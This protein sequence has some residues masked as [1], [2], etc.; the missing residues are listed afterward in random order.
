MN[1]LLVFIGGGLGSLI[2]YGIS[3]ATISHNKSLFPYAT[4]ITNILS[5]ICIGLLISYLP[6][7]N[8]SE[9]GKLL[10]ITGFCGGF[11][12]FSTLSLEV[13]NLIEKNEIILAILYVVLSIMFGIAAIWITCL[14]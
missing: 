12:T 5:C 1:W 13:F 4:F 8:F 9:N 10:F 14:K 11:S 3:L 2:R 7:T 6:K